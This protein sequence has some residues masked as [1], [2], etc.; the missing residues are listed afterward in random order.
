M[1]LCGC[2]SVSGRLHRYP[3]EYAAWSRDDGFLFTSPPF[4]QAVQQSCRHMLSTVT[5]VSINQLLSSSGT[6][7]F[8]HK[9]QSIQE[10]SSETPYLRQGELVVLKR[11]NYPSK[12]NHLRRLQVEPL[13]EHLEFVR[14]PADVELESGSLDRLQ[15]SSEKCVLVRLHLW[16]RY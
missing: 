9:Q 13:P 3:W 7:P 15:P 16:L 10:N 4:L 12:P 8:K 5:Q 6:S 1:N 2:S 11:D 14:R